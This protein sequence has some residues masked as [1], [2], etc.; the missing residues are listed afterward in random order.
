[1]KPAWKRVNLRSIEPLNYVVID[2][3][4]PLQDG[5]T[6]RLIDKAAILDSIPYS[7]CIISILVDEHNPITAHFLLFILCP[8]LLEYSTMSFPGQ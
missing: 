6:D 5:R 3:N 1:M 8:R 2:A 4:H 7:R